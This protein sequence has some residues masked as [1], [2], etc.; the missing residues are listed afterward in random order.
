MCQTPNT[1]SDGTQVACH[2]CWQCINARVDDYVGRCIAESKHAV[3]THAVTLTYGRDDDPESVTYGEKLHPRAV[4][5]TYSDV[6]KWL[7]LFRRHG[8]PCRYLITGEFGGEKGRAHWHA[9]IFWQD[10]V[11]II[12]VRDKRFMHQRLDWDTGEPVLVR[13][14]PAY[15]WPH[16]T[17]FWTEP[18]YAALRYNLKYVQKDIGAA[19]RQGHFAVSKKPPIGSAY[20]E[21]MAIGMVGYGLAP[22]GSGEDR[23]G[24]FTYTMPEAVRSDGE[25]VVFHLRDT[26]KR[27]FL[28]AWFD[29]W[30][31]RHFQ[32]DWTRFPIGPHECSNADVLAGYSRHG[33]VK[34]APWSRL[35]MEHVDPYAFKD[36]PERRAE[37]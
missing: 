3:A 27:R 9:V 28:D 36:T 8:Y 29:E 1:L 2:E 18:G 23:A 31:R 32:P 16:G 22:Q 12:P 35:L 25:R 5:L 4:V 19:E 11:P 15:W 37:R 13:G 10:R 33:A 7:K 17:S 34:K 24:P 21:Q 20:F 26:S 30:R 6:Q 14:K